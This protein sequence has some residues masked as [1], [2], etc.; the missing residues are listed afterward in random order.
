M[1]ADKVTFRIPGYHDTWVQATRESIIANT[2][3][4][5]AFDADADGEILLHGWSS[6]VFEFFMKL[7]QCDDYE[8]DDFLDEFEAEVKDVWSIASFH[9]E[10]VRQAEVRGDDT[11]TGEPGQITLRMREW[12]RRWWDDNGEGFRG[13]DAA[14]LTT[15]VMPAFYIG[16]A[17]VFMSV[18]HDWF[19]HVSGKQ[20][21]KEHA[22]MPVDSDD[23][24]T[25]VLDAQH[26]LLGTYSCHPLAHEQSNFFTVSYS[27]PQACPMRCKAMLQKNLPHELSSNMNL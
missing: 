5:D 24:A 15:L 4:L 10:Y 22:V 8:L 19:L 25:G 9:K 23:G 14:Q 21:A 26:P 13:A 2:A 11:E 27:S 3:L 18:T 17:Q 20:A 1:A 12:F 7:L 16:D 6:K